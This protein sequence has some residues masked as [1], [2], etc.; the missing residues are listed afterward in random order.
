MH[1]ANAQTNDLHPFSINSDQFRID[2]I[3]NTVM[4]QAKPYTLIVLRDKYNEQM[5]PF[6]KVVVGKNEE[7]LLE[8]AP[9]TIMIADKTNGGIVF[10][11]KIEIAGNNYPNLNWL[12]EKGQGKQLTQTGKLFFSV[13]KSYGGSGSTNAIYLIDTTEKGFQLSKLFAATGELSDYIVAN[14]DEEMIFITGIWNS[15]E[16]EAHFS[17]HRYQVNKIVFKKAGIETLNLGI[18]TFKYPSID[19]DSTCIAILT[20]ILKKEPTF[21]SKI[22]LSKFHPS[23]F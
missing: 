5:V 23:I 11:K 9:I 19:E 14:N 12:L 18:T 21:K 1:R 10:Y 7:L 3:F 2:T 22:Q 13:D 6:G 16:K 17:N 4:I 20:S 8:Q 15:K